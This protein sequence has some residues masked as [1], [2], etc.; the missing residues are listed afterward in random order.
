MAFHRED[1]AH[2]SNEQ[3]EAIPRIYNALGTIAAEGIMHMVHAE[4]IATINT[5]IQ[6]EQQT[7]RNAY[8]QAL[9]QQGGSTRSLKLE[10][11]KFSGNEK[12]N[13]TR[14]L[15]ELEMSI[16]VRN[17]SQ[18]EHK[19]AY[20]MSLLSGR[21]KNWAYGCRM[22]DT[23]CFKTY[24][25]FRES[26]EAAF[27]PPKCEFRLKAQL[28]SI[29]QGTRN[30]YDYVQEIR[31]LV[32]GIVNH[33]VDE[34][35]LVS[36]FLKGLKLGPVRTHLF[37]VYPETLEEAISTA[38]QEEFSRTQAMPTRMPPK[39]DPYAMDVSTIDK[40]GEGKPSRNGKIKCFRCGRLGH[41]AKSCYVKIDGNKKG[42]KKGVAFPNTRGSSKNE[43]NQ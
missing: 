26:L 1:F 9:V 29:Q 23:R 33:P 13:L 27:Q 6:N 40:R 20:A 22:R 30:L 5:F 16:N 42:N 43:L 36:I 24:E 19:V 21:A 11:A 8:H 37:R 39:K 31:Y 4:Q 25:E 41:M 17:L 7:V 10:V 18:E 28:L 12:E 34:N 2:L 14:W 38:V 3:F 15:T 35:T 32:S